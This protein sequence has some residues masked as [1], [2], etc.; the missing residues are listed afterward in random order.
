MEKNSRTPYTDICI[1]LAGGFFINVGILSHPKYVT[2]TVTANEA[3][4]FDGYKNNPIIIVEFICVSSDL[5]K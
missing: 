5:N 2:V 4:K 1:T 3:V